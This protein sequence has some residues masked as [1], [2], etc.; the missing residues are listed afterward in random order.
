M[1]RKAGVV[2][3]SFDARRSAT[4]R[5]YRYSVHN[6][7]APDPFAAATSWHVATPLDLRAMRL[8][9]DPILGEHDFSSFCRRPTSP[10]GSLVR[11]VR[12]ADW[13]EAGAGLLRFDIEA[14]SFCQQMVRSLVG[15]MVDIGLGRRKAGEMMAI[16]RAGDRGAAGRLAPPHGLCLWE[17]RYPDSRCQAGPPRSAPSR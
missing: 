17:V 6:A 14:S 2:S 4:S 9:C 12:A 3:P 15:T 10:G 8:A 1:V 13:A 7:P 16:L 5:R 11:R